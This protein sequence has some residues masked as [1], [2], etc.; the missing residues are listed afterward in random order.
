MHAYI[1][2][3]AHLWLSMLRRPSCRG[4]PTPCTSLTTFQQCYLYIYITVYCVLK[5]EHEHG[6]M[7]AAAVVNVAWI[8][9]ERI[10]LGRLTRARGFRIQN[11][12]KC[13]Q[14]S[15]NNLLTT[16]K[17]ELSTATFDSHWVAAQA[18]PF[19]QTKCSGI[20]GCWRTARGQTNTR[21][22]VILWQR[23]FS[24]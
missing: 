13:R 21:H 17:Q 9:Y 15:K 18:M 8:Q 6:T 2:T 24:L 7:A 10:A 12:L 14:A 3:P 23:H 20:R 4:W 22:E 1:H 19:R 5:A 11:W 16:K